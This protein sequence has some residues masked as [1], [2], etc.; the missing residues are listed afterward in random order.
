MGLLIK[1]KSFLPFVWGLIICL[2]FSACFKDI[3]TRTVVYENKFEDTAIHGF[4]I[5]SAIGIVDSL[6]IIEFNNTHI[7]GSF[8]ENLVRF[9]IDQIPTHNVLKIEF[10]L[11][12]H[13]DWKGNFLAPG[14]SIP[15]IWQMKLNDNPI[16]LT[17]FSN[18]I[19]DQSFPDNYQSVLINN[20]ALSNAW[21]TMAGICSKADQKD[22]TSYYKME[23]LSGHQGSAIQL[24]FQD[25]S[26]SPSTHCSK[27]WSIDNLK[28]SV[29]NQP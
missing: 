19:Y 26:F 20:K 8:H 18:G 5:L 24:D 9:N 17:T 4:I 22:G 27:S 3:P 16:Y 11:Y 14:S 1:N 12:L 25:V 23:I 28:I 13:D 21:G 29:I 6:K 15:D 10:D 7:L 2:S